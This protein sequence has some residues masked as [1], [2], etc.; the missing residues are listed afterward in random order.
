MRACSSRCSMFTM[1][2]SMSPPTVAAPWPCRRMAL[3]LPIRRAT[4]AP[5]FSWMMRR[6]LGNIGSGSAK[7]GMP[8][9]HIGPICSCRTLMRTV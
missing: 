5:S 2:S 4:S 1:A 3:W 6:G 9:M 7:S 8:S